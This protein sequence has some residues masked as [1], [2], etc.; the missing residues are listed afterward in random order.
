MNLDKTLADAIDAAGF[1]RRIA[2]AGFASHRRHPDDDSR[3]TVWANHAH[4]KPWR[5]CFDDPA[6]LVNVTRL[7]RDQDEVARFVAGLPKKGTDQ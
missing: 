6:N 4:R 1:T 3:L 2:T 5:L 7:F